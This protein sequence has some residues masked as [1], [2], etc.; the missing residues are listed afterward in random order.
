MPVDSARCSAGEVALI[1]TDTRRRIDAI[2]DEN[3]VMSIG[4]NRADGW[5]QV[6]QVNY[7]HHG[8]ALY[9]VVARDSQKL[10]NIQRDGRV[11][12]AL[13]GG[14]GKFPDCG[15]SMSAWAAE[16]VD[17][18]RIAQLNTLL[19]STSAG[20]TFRPHPAGVSVAVMEARPQIV[21]LI[22]YSEPPGRRETVAMAAER[23]P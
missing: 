3:H 11:S 13:G 21:C 12:I 8:A 19:W 15:L 4:A 18:E 10:A 17:V 20:A 1:T 14:D 16:V 6:T 23:A 22:D 2:L 5:P 9:F 7:L